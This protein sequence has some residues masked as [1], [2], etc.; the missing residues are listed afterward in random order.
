MPTTQSMSE[1]AQRMF[2]IIERYRNSNLTQK[3]F[4]EAE[5][6]ALST[7]QYWTSRYNKH[8]RVG[9]RSR[10]VGKRS[11]FV[12][13]LSAQAGK[14]QAATDAAIVL[15]YPNGVTVRLGSAAPLSVLKELI[16]L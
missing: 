12:E 6:L 7:F 14:P 16:T 13:L 11:G 10:S 8:R 1:R 5:G 4:C 9:Y 3:A 2:E 15:T